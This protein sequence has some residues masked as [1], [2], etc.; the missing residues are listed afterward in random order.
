MKSVPM[1]N[2]MSVGARVRGNLGQ[3]HASGYSNLL[4]PIRFAS[5]GVYYIRAP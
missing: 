5:G 4:F 1:F 3:L 2:N